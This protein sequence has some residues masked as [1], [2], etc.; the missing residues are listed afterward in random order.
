MNAQY[1]TI[2]GRARPFEYA[3][4]SPSDFVLEAGQTVDETVVLTDPTLSLYC[5]DPEQQRALF[6]ETPPEL[7][8]TRVPFMYVA[9]QEHAS[10]ILSVPISTMHELAVQ[11]PVR[12]EQITFI[13]STGRCGSTMVSAAFGAADNAVSLS[14]PDVHFITSQARAAG[15]MSDTEL[16]ALIGSTTRLLCRPTPQQRNPQAW[17]LKFRSQELLNADLFHAAFPSA[18]M[19][20]LSIS[21]RG[22]VAAFRTAFVCRNRRG[23]PPDR[24]S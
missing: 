15:A 23:D 19:L 6:V 21:E 22:Y 11:V 3:P 16:A 1:H 9:Q 18:N 20:A 24:D 13:F 5:L 17:A 10:R 7:D 12:D 8:L 14:E 4:A 2:K